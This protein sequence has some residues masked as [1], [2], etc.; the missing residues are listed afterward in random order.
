[1]D[2]N[3]H[4]LAYFGNEFIKYDEKGAIVREDL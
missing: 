2:Q 1:M 3:D 4:P